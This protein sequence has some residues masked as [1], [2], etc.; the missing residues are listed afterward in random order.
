MQKPQDIRIDEYDYPL[1]DERIAKYPLARRDASKLLLY[2]NGQILESTFCHLPELLPD[3]SLLV[4][5]NTRVIQARL[6]F[7]KETGALIEIF[8]LEP[9]DPCDYLMSFQTTGG[10]VWRC[11]VGNL[12]K[13][14]NGRLSR[15]LSV[16]GREVTLHAER[17]DHIDSETHEIRFSWDNEGITFA[18]L[19]E[20]FGELPIPP[21]LNRATEESD[22]E[23][24][25]TV[26]S[27]VEGSVDRKSVV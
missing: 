6:H 8:C 11:L 13:W 10:C 26:Y 27:H 19:L 22:K 17:Q 20:A 12:R 1:P 16:E 7:R 15:T 14:K 5:N 4:C 23:T 3:D 2:K 24:Y 9:L 21:Y 18:S 25:Q